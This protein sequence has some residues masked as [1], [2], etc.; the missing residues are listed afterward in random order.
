MKRSNIPAKAPVP[1][2]VRRLPYFTKEPNVVE[3][4]TNLSGLI[5]KTLEPANNYMVG[6][7]NDITEEAAALV[8]RRLEPDLLPEEYTGLKTVWGNLRRNPTSA[9]HKEAFNGVVT[10]IMYRATTGHYAPRPKG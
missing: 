7:D 4:V 6:G 10:Q 3:A 2:P 5:L 1:A 9:P 8:Y